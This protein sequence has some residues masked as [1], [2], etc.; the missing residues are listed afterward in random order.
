[1][2]GKKIKI[3]CAVRGRGDTIRTLMHYGFSIDSERHIEGA[4]AIELVLS[5]KDIGLNPEE[6]GKTVLSG[7]TKLIGD[8]FAVFM[9]IGENTYYFVDPK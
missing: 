2:R 5:H 1:M 8:S 7:G 9:T 3:G 4:E 6:L